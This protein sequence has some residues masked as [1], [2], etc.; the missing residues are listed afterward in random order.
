M[1]AGAWCRS[2]ISL[3][4]WGI[5]GAAISAPPVWHDPNALVLLSS[6]Y[7]TEP[8]Y[9]TLNRIRDAGIE[10][11]TGLGPDAILAYIP[12]SVRIALPEL[13]TLGIARIYQRRVDVRAFA[14]RSHGAAIAAGVWNKG[15]S[16]DREPDPTRRAPD[17]VVLSRSHAV[18]PPQGC[19]VLMPRITSTGFGQVNLDVGGTPPCPARYV[20]PPGGVGF[21]PE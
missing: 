2:G 3:V 7:W 21:I 16:P 12:E 13:R 8:A 9:C 11:K 18:F 14:R 5:G 10:F 17:P 20:E 15:Y 6:T 19:I 1:R 4:V